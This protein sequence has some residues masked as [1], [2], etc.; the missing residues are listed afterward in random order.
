MVWSALVGPTAAGTATEGMV[1]GRATLRHPLLLCCRPPS[2]HC[3]DFI[4]VPVTYTFYGF[5]LY[6]RPAEGG[7]QGDWRTWAVVGT[8]GGWLPASTRGTGACGR[9][10]SAMNRGGGGA[11]AWSRGGW[12][13]SRGAGGSTPR[14]PTIRARGRLPGHVAH[15]LVWLVEYAE[16]ISC[17]SAGQQPGT[18]PCSANK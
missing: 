1:A 10:T 14:T 9:R 3:L 11:T 15:A 16:C 7:E 2:T 17:R 12:Q 13:H 5:Y 4:V 6:N 8:S 18:G